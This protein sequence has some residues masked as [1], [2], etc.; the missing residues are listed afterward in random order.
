[1]EDHDQRF[2]TL[3]R[4]FFRELFLVFFPD[5]AKCFNF[6]KVEWLDKEIFPALPGV[7]YLEGKMLLGAA[8]SVLMKVP[9]ELRAELK[10]RALERVLKSKENAVRKNLLWECIETYLPLEGPALA[11][12]EDLLSTKYPE[13]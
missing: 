7:K 8:L 13:V 12:Y 1:M 2:K 10:A 4:E 6:G 11:E 5:W 3:V 9:P